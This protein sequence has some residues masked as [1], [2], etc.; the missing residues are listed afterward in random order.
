MEI[1]T[2]IKAEIISIELPF[3]YRIGGV[4]TYVINNDIPQYTTPTK[5]TLTASDV[6]DPMRITFKIVKY[7][8]SLGIEFP[9]VI[10]I[11]IVIICAFAS[12]AILYKMG[13]A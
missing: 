2:N 13:E 4:R 8:F 3:K 9:N 11:S 1:Y 10:G 12:I 6:V 5:Y 7:S